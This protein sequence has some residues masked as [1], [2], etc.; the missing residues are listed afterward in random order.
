MERIIDP[1]RLYQ[2]FKIDLHNAVE[3][4]IN[5]LFENQ[6]KL[7]WDKTKINLDHIHMMLDQCNTLKELESRLEEEIEI[8]VFDKEPYEKILVIVRE[9]IGRKHRI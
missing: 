9:I 5:E 7:Q 6:K 8:E 4:L 3:S 1:E 2:M